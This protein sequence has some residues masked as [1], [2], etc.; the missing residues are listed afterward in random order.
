MAPTPAARGREPCVAVSGDWPR[1][2]AS[3][4]ILKKVGAGAPKERPTRPSVAPWAAALSE[5][6]GVRGPRGRFTRS[7]VAPEWLCGGRREI[8]GTKKAGVGAKRVS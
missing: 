2:V 4:G 5:S 6:V 3:L 8:R 7:S 1:A